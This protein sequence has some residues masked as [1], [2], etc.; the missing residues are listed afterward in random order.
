[1][2]LEGSGT[3]I[4][5]IGGRT[6]GWNNVINWNRVFDLPKFAPRILWLPSTTAM[7]RRKVLIHG[8]RAGEGL[9]SNKRCLLSTS[10]SHKDYP[11]DK[12]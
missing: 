8:R 11:A 1:M 12:V 2:S 4:V 10:C 6:F 9:W 7:S 5:V 3:S